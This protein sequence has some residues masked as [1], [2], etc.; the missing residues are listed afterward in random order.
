MQGVDG[1]LPGASSTSVKM[2]TKTC[3]HVSFL[4]LFSGAKTTCCSLS[5]M[6]SFAK[7]RNYREIDIPFILIRVWIYGYIHTSAWSRYSKLENSTS[8][9]P[10]KSNSAK[11]ELEKTWKTCI[12]RAKTRNTL[13]HARTRQFETLWNSNSIWSEL[14]Q[15]QVWFFPNSIVT[16]CPKLRVLLQT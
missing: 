4:P 11:L 5:K 12:T 2:Y 10:Q 3:N 7:I 6:K 8:F 16:F 1:L 9:N 14:V 13:A 15:A